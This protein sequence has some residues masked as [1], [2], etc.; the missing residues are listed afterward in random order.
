MSVSEWVAVFTLALVFLALAVTAVRILDRVLLIQS[1]S[2]RDE[3]VGDSDEDGPPEPVVSRTSS[4]CDRPGCSVAAIHDH[5][6]GR[7]QAAS[8]CNI[9]GCRISKHHSHVEDFA[10]RLREKKSPPA[11]PAPPAK[12][13]THDC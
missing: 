3:D 6:E 12:G 4:R 5:L 1:R 9:P 10:R 13:E 7:P 2:S 8:L 11:E